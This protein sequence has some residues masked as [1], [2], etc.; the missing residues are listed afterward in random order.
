MCSFRLIF[1]V[2]QRWVCIRIDALGGMFSAGLAAYLVYAHDL[3]T[4]ANTGFS[5]NQA[6]MS[7]FYDATWIESY[8]GI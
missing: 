1:N 5:L 7:I 2:S 6:G 3:P 4:A 8:Y